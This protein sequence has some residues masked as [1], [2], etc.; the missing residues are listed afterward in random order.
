LSLS[1]LVAEPFNSLAR[2][3]DESENSL[4]ETARNRL[5]LMIAP[6][7]TQQSRIQPMI[8]C[9]PAFPRGSPMKKTGPAHLAVPGPVVNQRSPGPLD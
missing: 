1:T 6:R 7:E 3:S 5:T 4:D 2:Q 9:W 8:R